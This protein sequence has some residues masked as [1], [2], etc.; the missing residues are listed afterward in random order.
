MVEDGDVF[1][2][3]KTFVAVFYLTH[4]FK[5]ALNVTLPSKPIN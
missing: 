3:F 1:S 4:Y 2:L 5:A